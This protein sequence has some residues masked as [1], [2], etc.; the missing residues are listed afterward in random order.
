MLTAIFCPASASGACAALLPPYTRG[1]LNGTVQGRSGATPYVRWG[2]APVV[3]LASLV[4][5][6]FALGRRR[7]ALR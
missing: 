3:A 1:T 2:N 5:G 6:L 7:P 4:C